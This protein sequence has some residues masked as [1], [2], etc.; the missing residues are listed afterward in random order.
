MRPEERRTASVLFFANRSPMQSIYMSLR[1]R[2]SVF[3]RRLR[4]EMF[5]TGLL[6]NFYRPRLSGQL[7][8]CG[9]PGCVN[10]QLASALGPEQRKNGADV[11][12]SGRAAWGKGIWLSAAKFPIGQLLQPMSPQILVGTPSSRSASA[13]ERNRLEGIWRPQ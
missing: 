10:S 13:S 4:S 8:N 7:V 2:S 9:W 12:Q 1:N 3:Y 5:H 11:V 6:L